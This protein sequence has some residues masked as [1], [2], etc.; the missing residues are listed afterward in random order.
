[1]YQIEVAHQFAA[2]HAVTIRG[3]QETV[4]GHD[5]LVTVILGTDA[6]D[7]DGLALDF[8]DL[9]ARL[10]R[11]LDPFAQRHLNE[12]PPF[13]GINPTA[14]LLAKHVADQ[15]APDLPERVRIDAVR[16]REAPHCVAVYHPPA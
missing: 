6:L 15:L 7:E 1:M 13:D 14:E 5:W 9:R 3:E 4:H 10:R 11:V 2:A 16:V 12:T 8:L